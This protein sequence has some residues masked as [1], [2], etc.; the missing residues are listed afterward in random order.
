MNKKKEEEKHNRKYEKIKES[1]NEKIIE[2]GN[3]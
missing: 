1:N 2:E 3:I